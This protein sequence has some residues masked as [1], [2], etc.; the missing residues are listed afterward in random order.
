[1]F[2]QNL[3]KVVGLRETR[4]HMY[5]GANPRAAL[6]VNKIKNMA[7]LLQVLGAPISKLFLNTFDN[8]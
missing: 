6:K 4:S 2:Q 1:M 7:D 8:C 5:F 3:T